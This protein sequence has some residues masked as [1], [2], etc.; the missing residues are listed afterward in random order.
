M[1]SILSSRFF[2]FL[3]HYTPR[4]FSSTS[5]A[6]S[7]PPLWPN[8]VWL[9]D[10]SWNLWLSTSSQPQFMNSWKYALIECL[11]ERNQRG[12]LYLL[13]YHRQHARHPI[14]PSDYWNILHHAIFLWPES[15][16]DFTRQFHIDAPINLS[17]LD[18]DS[19]TFHLTSLALEPPDSL[20][21]RSFPSS[22]NSMMRWNFSLW[23]AE[24]PH[25]SIA[26][27]MNWSHWFL[28]L[29]GPIHQS[30]NLESFPQIS[31][32]PCTSPFFWTQLY[33][34]LE[35]WTASCE[36]SK[37]DVLKSILNCLE[38]SSPSHAFPSFYS[39]VLEA[40]FLNLSRTPEHSLDVLTF[41]L[42]DPS[43]L[44]KIPP[45]PQLNPSLYRL[46][47]YIPELSASSQLRFHHL[48]DSLFDHSYWNAH[49][50]QHPEASLHFS[51]PQSFF[52]SHL[53]SL[54]E[55]HL[56]TQLITQSSSAPS[57]QSRLTPRL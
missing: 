8:A 29:I 18:C 52:S 56:L 15:A 28:R 51:Y 47:Y 27:P 12:I 23:L 44:S 41:L 20:L 10:P 14:S 55:R 46:F 33:P 13:Q 43:C 1:K 3:K 40:A 57:P 2:S 24:H 36:P 9:D 32:A 31:T 42:T 19:W 34:A 26:S 38:T 35:A 16:Y 25:S 22:P 7:S 53:K 54:L 49:F 21:Y 37:P 45:A 5:H 17:S 4:L 30:I 50:H 6:L 39:H 48:L 11:S